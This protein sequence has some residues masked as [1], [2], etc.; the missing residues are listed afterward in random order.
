MHNCITG[1]TLPR[2]LRVVIA[3]LVGIGLLAAAPD[4][5]QAA[6][7]K[8]SSVSRAAIAARMVVVHGR[9]ERQ[10][11]GIAVD[12]IGDPYRYGAAGPHA[13]DCSGLTSFALHH[14]GFRRVPRTSGAQAQFVHR[15]HKRN[16]KVGDLM[17]FTSGGRVYH[18][19]FF[20]GWRHHH[21]IVLHAPHTGSHVRRQRVWTHH[22]FA[23]TLRFR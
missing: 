9:M 20:A 3:T 19:G 11:V 23:G 14:A 5:S 10:A 15:I 8:K 22:W 4:P 16:M 13:F 12:K 18:V 2:W 21:R 7:V 1:S 6:T 17:F